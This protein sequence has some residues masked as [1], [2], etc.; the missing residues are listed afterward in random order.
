MAANSRLLI[1]CQLSQD[2]SF[3][4]KISCPS[5]CAAIIDVMDQVGLNPASEKDKHPRKGE[6]YLDR[7]NATFIDPKINDA[8][9]SRLQPFVP[10]VDGKAATGLF[11]RLRY[12]IYRRGQRFD[13]H[14]DTSVHSSLGTSEYT[15]L[16]YLNGQEESLPPLQGGETVFYKNVRTV[17]ASVAPEAGAALLHAHGRRCLMHEGAQVTKGS[18]YMLRSDV[19]F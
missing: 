2:S 15:F 17:L 18:K 3:S 8:L 1:W 13:Q 12:Y 7:E 4:S 5:E 11:E 16:V 14:V 9:F 10:T 6:A 19:M